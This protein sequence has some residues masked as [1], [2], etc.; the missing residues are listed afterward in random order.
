M[1]AQQVPPPAPRRRA[2]HLLDPDDLGRRPRDLAA[3]KR[4]L[5]RVQ[6]WVMSVL[7]VTTILHL[8]AG[9]VLA[10][11]FLPAERGDGARIGL[12]VIAAI[13]GVLAVA[14]GR[15]IHRRSV[16]S[17]WLVLGVLPGVIGV[18]LTL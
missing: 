8:S 13:F 17:P 4:S 1:S 11:H 18:W 2:R 15:A 3:E 12:D 5:T 7:A 10:A 9:L 16:L 6:Q 14:A